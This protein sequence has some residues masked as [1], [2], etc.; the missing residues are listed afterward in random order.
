M[1]AAVTPQTNRAGFLSTALQ[2]YKSQT[3][4]SAFTW[5]AIAL[6]NFATQ[7]ILYKEMSTTS[8]GQFGLLTAIL[9]IIGLLIVPLAALQQALRLY[10]GP[11]ELRSSAVLAVE[12]SAWLWAILYLLAVLVLSILGTPNFSLEL[13]LLFLALGGV[14]SQAVCES[15]TRPH[16]WSRLMFIA[17]LVRVALAIGLIYTPF[18]RRTEIGVAIFLIAGFVTLA[19]ALQPRDFDWHARLKS[20]RALYHRD[21][22]LFLAA[23]LSVFLGLYLFTNA[24]RIAALTWQGVLDDGRTHAGVDGRKVNLDS[25]QFLGLLA[26]GLLW[27]TQPL[28][29][30]LFAQRTRLTKTTSAS[31]TFFWIYLVAL[32]TGAFALGFTTHGIS[33]T[34]RGDFGPTFCAVMVPLGVIQAFG[35]FSLAS[36]R[37]P[38]CFTVGLCGIVYTLILTLFAHRSDIMLAYM[39]GLSLIS[40]MIILAVGVVRWGRKQP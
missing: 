36:R 33:T 23:T 17:A 9:G 14:V 18:D 26:R 1:N 15:E 34:S 12:T 11:A 32:V 37:Y 38:E 19:P 24:D 30:I 20:F 21:F 31:M 7:L 28:L 29:W 8:P 10:S 25:Y 27:G 3:G 16:R 22:F 6:L 2:A 5:L 4:Q 39:F 35:I 13:I 40:M